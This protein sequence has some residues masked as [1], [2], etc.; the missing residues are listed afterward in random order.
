MFRRVLFRSIELRWGDLFR[1]GYHRGITHLHHFYTPRNF[2]ALATL[3][4]LVKD[5]DA[6][7]QDAL[8][9]LVLSFN[10]SH[11]TLMTRVV[12]KTGQRDLVLT[13]AQS[14]VLYVSGLPVEKNVFDGVHRKISTLSSAFALVVGSGSSVSVT[15]GSSTSMTLDSRSIQYVFT[16]PPFGAYI[17]YAEINQLNEGWLGA[18]TDRA[19]S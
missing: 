6:D 16:D 9:L 18:A 12:V 15:N 2:L 17:P 14:G 19:R 11:S 4:D 7:L 13:G 1:A 10:A 3:W 8:R 5:F